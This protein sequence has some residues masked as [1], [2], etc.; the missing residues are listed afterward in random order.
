MPIFLAGDIR[1]GAQAIIQ[2]E[3]DTVSDYLDI[4]YIFWIKRAVF[5]FPSPGVDSYGWLRMAKTFLVAGKVASAKAKASSKLLAAVKDKDPWK[6]CPVAHCSSCEQDTSSV[7][8]DSSTSAPKFLRWTAW[9]TIKCK[10]TK[11]QKRVPA[12]RECY[13]CFF[14]RRKYFRK[15]AETKKGI[16]K[17]SCKKGGRSKGEKDSSDENDDDGCKGKGST[18]AMSQ[19]EV[20]DMRKEKPEVEDKFWELRQDVVGELGEHKKDDISHLFV[21]TEKKDE[22]YDD[23]HVTAEFFPLHEFAEKEGIEFESEKEL[24]AKIQHGWKSATIGFDKSDVLGV[25]LPHQRGGS[26]LIQRGRRSG[27]TLRKVESHASRADANEAFDA[28][29]AS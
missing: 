6:G 29:V 28:K 14:I 5:S 22:N 25:E 12:G 13:P 11:K 20:S 9:T 16:Q 26:Y 19:I 27:T 2:N 21:T 17:L 15:K 1:H 7:D 24:I 8:R 4:F 10:S 18:V 23:E 3:H